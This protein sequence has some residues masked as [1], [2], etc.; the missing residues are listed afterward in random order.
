MDIYEAALAHGQQ[1]R[2]ELSF[3]EVPEWQV[4]DGEGG[5]CPAKIYFYQNITVA[6][7]I[8]IGKEVNQTTG[9][10]SSGNCQR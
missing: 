9:E 4:D 7:Q 6:E 5:L 10:M 3:I 1:S 2:G 8:E